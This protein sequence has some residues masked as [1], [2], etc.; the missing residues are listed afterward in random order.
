[1][2]HLPLFFWPYL[3]SFFTFLFPLGLFFPLLSSHSPSSTLPSMYSLYN[4]RFCLFPLLVA[5]SHVLPFLTLLVSSIPVFFSSLPSP[6]FSPLHPLL[7][8]SLPTLHLHSLFIPPL[9]LP[10]HTSHLPLSF[11]LPPFQS[12]PLL[13]CLHF[14]LLYLNSY[15]HL[16][17]TFESICRTLLPLAF[18]VVLPPL[19]LSLYLSFQPILSPLHGFSSR[20]TPPFHSADY[21]GTIPRV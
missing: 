6:V 18:L 1:M 12:S 9:W 11:P 3:F 19:S 20:L 2:F 14:P 8:Y 17:F 7:M 21:P 15:I 10:F 5:I 4:R 16:T 13:S